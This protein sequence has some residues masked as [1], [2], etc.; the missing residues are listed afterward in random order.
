[1]AKQP[2]KKKLAA[3]VAL[4]RRGGKARVP[5]GIA[6]L[7]AEERTLRAKQGAAARWA[8]VRASQPAAT[9]GRQP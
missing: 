3:A 5:K 4:G 2:K 6:V 9:E 1:M 7:S 8:K